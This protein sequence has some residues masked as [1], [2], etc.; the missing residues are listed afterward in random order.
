MFVQIA[1]LSFLTFVSVVK[2]ASY[3]LRNRYRLKYRNDNKEAKIASLICSK[4]E[5]INKKLVE[6]LKKE[7]DVY[8]LTGGKN[9][10]EAINDWVKKHG[11]NYDFVGIFDY[12]SEVEEGFYK[13][14]LK[15]FD[16]G[17]AFVQSKIY[18]NDGFM[19]EEVQRFFENRIPI[20]FLSC[21]HNVVYRGDVLLKNPLPET[22]GEDFLHSIELFKK[23]Y[24]SVLAEDV[25]SYET[26]PK[27]L[28]F[29]ERDIK[30]SGLETLY[31]R[32]IPEVFKLKIPILKRLEIITDFL[33][34][35][36]ALIV[37]LT[38]LFFRLDIISQIIAILLGAIASRPKTIKSILLLPLLTTSAF[39][40][41]KGFFTNK[42]VFIT[43][44]QLNYKKYVIAIL[45]LNIIISFVYVI[46]F[47]NIVFFSLLLITS[48]ILLVKICIE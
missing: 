13:K 44:S 29:I 45:A 30:W 38:M 4:N 25:K 14:I 43:T 42:K 7:S 35:P 32:K 22:M 3:L 41:I 33:R 23:G 1:F 26:N 16:D 28:K 10:A 36:I 11:K 2:I 37:I 47:V 8:I 19:K 46:N 9:K 24:K 34:C 18:G 6:V 15:Y 39:G 12:D 20:Y 27:T 40:F 5:K 21:G 31:V 17:V 48:I